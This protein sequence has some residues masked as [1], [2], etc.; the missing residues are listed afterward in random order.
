MRG[1]YSCF[2]VTDLACVLFRVCHQDMFVSLSYYGSTTALAICSLLVRF[3][4]FL[5]K[6]S[7]N[8]VRV[9]ETD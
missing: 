4:T 6:L 3:S 1:H 7:D 2:L 9:M 5:K 8:L